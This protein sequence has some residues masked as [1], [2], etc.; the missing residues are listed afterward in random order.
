M[1]LMRQAFATLIM[2]AQ[3][4]LEKVQP[5]VACADLVSST[6]G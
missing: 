6:L 4:C 2:A 3:V 5:A 1:V